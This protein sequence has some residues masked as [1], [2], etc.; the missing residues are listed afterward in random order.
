MELKEAERVHEKEQGR[1]GRCFK[2]IYV[3]WISHE[4]KNSSITA[5]KPS[6]EAK[7]EKSLRGGCV[8]G[9]QKKTSRDIIL[10]SLQRSS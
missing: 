8:L 4:N 5:L 6:C 2:E 3:Y 1:A 10:F 9:L 7:E